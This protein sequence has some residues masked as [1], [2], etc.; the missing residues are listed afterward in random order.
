MKAFRLE[1]SSVL[2]LLIVTFF[3]AC[4]EETVYEFGDMQTDFGTVTVYKAPSDGFLTIQFHSNVVS[5]DVFVR[6]YSDSNENPS[7]VI[8]EMTFSG[9]ITLP[10]KKNNYW[11]IVMGNSGTI[12]IGFTPLLSFTE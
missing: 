7:T 11:K 5:D 12:K 8:G 1:S 3:S 2:F 9:T 6:A 4:Q 10:I